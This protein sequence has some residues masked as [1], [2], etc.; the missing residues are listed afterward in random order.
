MHYVE[1]D[2]CKFSI[3]FVMPSLKYSRNKYW[4]LA[5]SECFINHYPKIKQLIILSSNPFS[6]ELKIWA[7]TGIRDISASILAYCLIQNNSCTLP[8]KYPS[9]FLPAMPQFASAITRDNILWHSAQWSSYLGRGWQLFHQIE[10]NET[11][12]LFYI[13]QI[14]EN[15]LFPMCLHAIFYFYEKP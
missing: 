13:W 4:N 5:R 8:H 3:H 1:L 11:F 10:V 15:I 12:I 6:L 2:F 9:L 14:K 7:M